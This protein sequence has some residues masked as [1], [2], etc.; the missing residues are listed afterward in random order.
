M[1]QPFEKNLDLNN[2]NSTPRPKETIEQIRHKNT[3]IKPQ[4]K[5]L[6]GRNVSD[7]AELNQQI[8]NKMQKQQEIIKNNKEKKVDN[9]HSSEIHT[10]K[11]F[12]SQSDQHHIFETDATHDQG[13][14]SKLKEKIK[15][16]SD[17]L[18]KIDTDQHS[19]EGEKLSQKDSL[20]NA[21][22]KDDAEKRRTFNMANGVVGERS[23]G[24]SGGSGTQ[25]GETLSRNLNMVKDFVSY[26]K[27][28]L[29]DVKKAIDEIEIYK[30]EDYGYNSKFVKNAVKLV[31]SA[32]EEVSKEFSW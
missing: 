18:K 21:L 7:L 14:K 28:R 30:E 24:Y 6:L 3:F 15:Y 19:K 2:S 32:K 23:W 26:G 10:K 25:I 4:E 20:R 11:D 16:S 9:S 29:K 13:I 12:E 5:T 17:S 8:M 31:K 27:G 1:S 22:G